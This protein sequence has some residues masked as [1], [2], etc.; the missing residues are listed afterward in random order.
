MS[1]GAT[2][3]AF[4]IGD[5][6]WLAPAFFVPGAEPDRDIGRAFTATGKPCGCDAAIW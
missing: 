6:E 4:S 2:G 1:K 3:G 5:G